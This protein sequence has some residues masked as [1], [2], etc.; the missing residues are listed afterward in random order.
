MKK[1]LTVTATLAVL[2]I[3]CL[4]SAKN[5]Q[6][7]SGSVLI[8][9]QPVSGE[10]KELVSINGVPAIRFVSKDGWSS[11]VYFQKHQGENAFAIPVW[12]IE[13]IKIDRGWLYISRQR[14]SYVPDREK[15]DGF[16]VSRSEVRK[17]KSNSTG[18]WNPRNRGNYLEIDIGSSRNFWIYFDGAPQ[19]A[20][21][22]GLGGSFQRPV[23]NFIDR[24]IADFDKAAQEFQQLTTGLDVASA[25]PYF[26]VTTSPLE[27][28]EKYDRFMDSTTISTSTM[29]LRNAPDENYSLGVAASVVYMGTK[30]VRPDSVTMRF[31]A[32]SL[33]NILLNDDDRQVIFLIDGVRF[34][35]GTLRI[36]SEETAATNAPSPN[37]KNTIFKTTASIILPTG[38][39]EK[40]I[41][42]EKVEIKIGNIEA[43][44][45]DQHLGAFKKL[46][47]LVNVSAPK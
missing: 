9:G 43:Q 36:D 29:I 28:S 8:P 34:K 24:I 39:F 32:G 22:I 11:L 12:H 4:V 26:G 3:F 38:I 30:P 41:N 40:M 25:P 18:M 13:G 15:S 10:R 21:R 44:L 1:G 31:N 5:A 2:V 14:I 17:A 27:I 7:S 6:T 20:S 42:A 16:D 33:K 23:L 46:M 35:A 19:I 45:G 37:L 47:T